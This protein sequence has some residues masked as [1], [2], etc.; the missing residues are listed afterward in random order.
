MENCNNSPLS[1]STAWALIVSPSS[2]ARGRAFSCCSLVVGRLAKLIKDAAFCSFQCFCR[3]NL[4]DL[5]SIE[6][7]T[8]NCCWRITCTCGNLLSVMLS[9]R[10]RLRQNICA[11]PHLQFLISWLRG[12]EQLRPWCATRLSSFAHSPFGPS[13]RGLWAGT[14]LPSQLDVNHW[15]VFHLKAVSAHAGQ[16]RSQTTAYALPGAACPAGMNSSLALHATSKEDVEIFEENKTK[17]HYSKGLAWDAT[18]RPQ[19]KPTSKQW[20]ARLEPMVK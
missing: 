8:N 14:T 2:C 1:Q 18:L 10:G 16:S 17:P 5:H 6:P 13:K 3:V 19:F 15:V 20:Q 7:S 11:A 9:F 12:T 4:L